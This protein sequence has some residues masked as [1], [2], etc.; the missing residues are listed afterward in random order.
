MSIMVISPSLPFTPVRSPSGDIVVFYTG[1]EPRMSR[2]QALAFADQLR[3]LAA[4]A[5]GAGM[6]EALRRVDR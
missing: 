3:E 2:E 5:P 1:T 4:E 6:A